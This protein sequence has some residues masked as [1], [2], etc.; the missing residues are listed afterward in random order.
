MFWTISNIILAVAETLTLWGAIF[1]FMNV[2]NRTIFRKKGWYVL[3]FVLAF[4]SVFCSYVVL[5]NSWLGVVVQFLMTILLGAVLFHRNIMALILDLT[6][7]VLIFLAMECG[8]FIFNT[9][10]PLIN[11]GN[12]MLFA[13]LCILTKI[14]FML[15]IAWIMVK[16]RREQKMVPLTARQ[17]ASV[18]V[19]PV[20][21]VFFVVSLMEMM[22]VYV[23]LKGFGLVLANCFA[24]LGLNIYFFYLFH[25]LFRAK[26]LEEEMRIYQAQNEARY[27]HYEELEYKYRESRKVLHDMKNHLQAVEQ[28]YGEKNKEAGDA[29]VKDL[30]H[31]INVLGEKYYSSN[32]M[33]NIILNEKVSMAQRAGIQVE[34]QVGDADFSDLKDMDI[35]AIFANL[36]DN[37]VEA[38]AQCGDGAYL[39]IK[40]NTVQDFRVIHIRNSR[41][42]KPVKKQD[43]AG[44]MGLGLKNVRFTLAKY[45]GSL[46]QSVTEKEYRVSVMIPGKGEGAV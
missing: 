3:G 17:T 38:A 8:I 34:A 21:S 4:A 35:T 31:M 45:H 27:Y 24:I 33:L 23:Q 10:G 32:H 13:N 19:L 22:M 15:V 44:H 7:S 41:T 1:A 36:L 11:A 40:I 14:I 37:A 39:S 29:Y 6:F 18:L 12:Y 46:E 5:R 9:A 43:K 30:Y 28:L 26:G 16:W 25:Y 2:N 20:F 42:T